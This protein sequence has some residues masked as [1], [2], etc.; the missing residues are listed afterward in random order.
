MQNNESFAFKKQCFLQAKYLLS[1]GVIHIWII[2]FFFLSTNGVLIF[3][4]LTVD[5]YMQTN[6]LEIKT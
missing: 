5:K 3:D 4:S 6:Y 1:H 2:S